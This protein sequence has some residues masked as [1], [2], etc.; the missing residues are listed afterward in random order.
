MKLK[1]KTAIITGAGQGIGRGIA[2]RFADEGAK[3]VI[4]DLP[5]SKGAAVEEE[6]RQSGAEALFIEAD[7]S[8]EEMVAELFRKAIT[9]F[10]GVDILVNNAGILTPQ[11]PFEDTETA[12]FDKVI[13]VN[14]RGPFLCSREAIRHFKPKGG[15]CIV[16][17]TSVGGV[18]PRE[19]MV[20]YAASKAGSIM[21][22]QV[23]AK[24]Y[25]QC[26]IRANVVAP[27]TVETEIPITDELKQVFLESIPNKTLNTP[28]D[29]A[30][31]VVFLASDEA[32]QITGVVLPVDGGRLLN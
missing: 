30:N 32:R 12:Y 8:S 5:G 25:A 18:K 3:V 6:L 9:H 26:H 20:P 2:K 19:G 16:N 22:A 15:G 27:G 21:I 13:A 17:I 11:I 14:L 23:I 4:A 31:A 24:E 10:G 7:V 29:I 28:E 1:G